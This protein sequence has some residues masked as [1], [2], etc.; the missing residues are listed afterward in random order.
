MR[1]RFTELQARH[2]QIGDVRGLGPMLALEFVHDGASKRPA[3]EIATA[4]AEAALRH[5]LMI[6]KAGMHGNCLRVLVALVATDEQ[7]EE[8]LDVFA[9]AVAEALGATTAVAAATL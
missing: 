2:P 6:L 3:P 4:V 1:T 7:I 8:S 5:G 9:E